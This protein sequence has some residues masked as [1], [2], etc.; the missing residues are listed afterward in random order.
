MK[1]NM[2]RLLA[3]MLTILI[4][5]TTAFSVNST[6]LYAKG[7][8]EEKK[9]VNKKVK[10][11]VVPKLSITSKSLQ[12]INETFEI[13]LKDTDDVKKVTWYT[14]ND[15][16][17]TIT[18]SKDNSMKATVTAVRKGVT[19][20]RA[21]VTLNSGRV[22][23]LSTKVTVES[24]S[25]FD[26]T[27]TVQA[28]LVSLVRSDSKTLTAT[29]DKNIEI[30]GIVLF[31]NKTQVVEGTLDSKDGKKVTYSIPTELQNQ[32]GWQ[33]V[34]IGYY[35]SP[36]VIIKNGNLPKFTEQYVD[37][38]IQTIL[39]LPAPQ[40]VI[41]DQSNN[42]ILYVYFGQKLD[43]ATAETIS[44]YYIGGL[45]ILSAE[46]TYQNNQSAVKLKLKDGVI[47]AT[48][49]VNVVISGL[50]GENNT[51]STMNVYQG[52]ITL[53]ENIAP[54]LTSYFYTYP[55]TINL[56]FNENITGTVSFK[57]LQNNT[58]LFSYGLAS[59][60]T[61]TLVLKSTP[62]ANVSML[63]TPN[64]TN[65]IKDVVGNVTTSDL[66]KYIVPAY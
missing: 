25:K 54:V 16:V 38:T 27:T 32:T 7:K 4:I 19:F 2:Y 66:N 47:S 57:V 64:T 24:S 31:N 61:V 56:I 59:G 30:P 34:W 36:N 26:D 45:Q 50:K 10:K 29:F 52:T 60:N 8:H 42:S 22:Y 3:Y 11:E 1:K 21:K 20:V 65:Q 28:K 5:S 14:L 58:D 53:K 51:Y 37:F 48:G 23:R 63:I 39:P 41:Q 12:Y 33:K 13:T 46:L 18:V 55:N 40:A 17:A 62:T 15:K 6:V 43:K 9:D 44:N 49:S 35:S